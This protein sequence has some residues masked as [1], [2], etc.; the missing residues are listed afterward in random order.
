MINTHH[1]TVFLHEAE[2]SI[3]QSTV[4]LLEQMET[5]LIPPAY[6][7]SLS[8]A[9]LIFPLQVTVFFS[10]FFQISLVIILKKKEKSQR[11]SSSISALFGYS[12]FKILWLCPHLILLERPKLGTD[13]ENGLGGESASSFR[14]MTDVLSCQISRI[15]MN[16]QA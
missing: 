12:I 13:R 5:L 3:L 4:T 1:R 16:I 14:E 2:G 10:S 6:R 9:L 11:C 8:C 15:P 7:T